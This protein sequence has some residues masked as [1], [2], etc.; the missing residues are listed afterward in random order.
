[1]EGK[2]YRGYRRGGDFAFRGGREKHEMHRSCPDHRIEFQLKAYPANRDESGIP[3]GNSE[4]PVDSGEMRLGAVSSTSWT[5]VIH[6]DSQLPTRQ[7]ID[8]G[9]RRQ[10]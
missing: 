10:L 5:R 9:V 7:S 3:Y 8:R 1:L 4:R 2:N 6:S